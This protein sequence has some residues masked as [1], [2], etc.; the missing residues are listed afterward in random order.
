M[1]AAEF[2]EAVKDWLHSNYPKGASQA[3]PTSDIAVEWLARL[4]EKGWTAPHWPVEYGGAGLDPRHHRI[5]L[6]EML[7]VGASIPEG[8]M[9]MGL[10]GPTL[11][12]YGTEEQKQRH[13]IPIVRRELRWCQG[14]SEPGAGSDLANVQTRAVDQGD[15]F[16]VNGQKI[17][18]SGANFADWIFALVRTDTSA[19]KHD[20]IS[21]LLMDMHQPGIR[22][23]PIQLI[24][25]ASPFCETFFDNAVAR[26]DDL[27]GQLNQGWAVGKRLLQHERSGGLRVTP[28]RPAKRRSSGDRM[29]NLAKKY[30]GEADGKIADPSLRDDVLRHRMTQ[31]ALALTQARAKAENKSGHTPAEATSIFKLVGSTLIQNDSNLANRLMGFKGCGWERDNFEDLEFET[32]RSWLGGRSHTIYGGTNEI[33]LN[34]IAKRMLGLPD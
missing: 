30:L 34:I 25:G 16:L 28:R 21:F 13:L 23:R 4:V 26:K 14:Y 24:S 9:G 20:G 11:L 22:T 17:W 8:G 12:E 5:L 2:R 15:Y 31:Q 33:Q 32:T 3:E 19:P 27:V 6:E 29:G 7:A 10:I 1:S 18:T